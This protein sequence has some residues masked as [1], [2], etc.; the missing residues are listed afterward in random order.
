ML[1]LKLVGQHQMR[2]SV[3]LFKKQAEQNQN[4][5][6]TKW[7]QIVVQH[8]FSLHLPQLLSLLISIPSPLLLNR[9][10]F[11]YSSRV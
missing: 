10:C 6:A 1:Y 2:E 5:T 8:H 11:S 4:P 9:R 3:F 7:H